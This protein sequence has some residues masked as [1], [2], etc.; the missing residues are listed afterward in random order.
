MKRNS[1]NGLAILAG[2]MAFVGSASAV[3][4]IV[5]GN[6]EN[7]TGAGI[8]RNGGKPNPGVGGG[9]TTFSTYLYSTEYANPGPAG[10]GIQFLRPY[11]PNQ[12]ITQWV[13]L[14]N[15]TSL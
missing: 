2:G 5:D 12:S 4:I 13:S 14:T 11:A 9:W 6:L 1:N 10:C 7:T 15:L 3:D 8:V